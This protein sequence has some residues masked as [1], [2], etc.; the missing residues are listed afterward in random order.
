MI[1]ESV[2]EGSDFAS[3]SSNAFLNRQ[4]SFLNG[5]DAPDCDYWIKTISKH[6]QKRNNVLPSNK[7]GKI[8]KIRYND[9][10]TLP[11]RKKLRPRSEENKHDSDSKPS[12]QPGSDG[13]ALVAA[14]CHSY[15]AMRSGAFM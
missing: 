15:F 13:F 1:R 8:I 2:M 14:F 6:F 3:Q 7:K 9:F 4:N 10:V 11:Q 12:S 5:R